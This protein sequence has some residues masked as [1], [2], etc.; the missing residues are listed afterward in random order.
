MPVT[1]GSVGRWAGGLVFWWGDWSVVRW[2][3]GSVGGWVVGSLAVGQ[4]T[5]LNFY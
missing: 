4:C 1:V 2:A 3:G 5:V